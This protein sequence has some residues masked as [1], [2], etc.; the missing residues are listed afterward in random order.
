MTVKLVDLARESVRILKGLYPEGI[1]SDELA[2]RLNV[3]KRRVYDIV[4]VLKGLNMITT[5]RKYDGTTITWIDPSE[6]YVLRIEYEDLREQ[7]NAMRESRNQ[8]YDQVAELKEQLRI[9]R[10]KIHY[11]EQAVESTEKTEFRTRQLT[12]RPMSS[13]GFKRVKNGSVEVVIE[14]HDPGIIV[15]PTEKESDEQQVLLKTLQKI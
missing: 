14:T 12:I 10:S 6:K 5:Q 9:A 3:P 1:K 4:A 2:E 11:S 15:D 13:R 7:L 8:L